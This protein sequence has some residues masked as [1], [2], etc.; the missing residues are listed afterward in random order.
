MTTVYEFKWR[1]EILWALLTAALVAVT[2]IVQSTDP[3]TVTDLRVYVV[4]LAGAAGRAVLGALLSVT[5]R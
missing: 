5:G 1:P 4:A 3:A 2:Q